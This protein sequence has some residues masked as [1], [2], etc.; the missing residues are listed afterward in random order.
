MLRGPRPAASTGEQDPP[1]ATAR[2]YPTRQ[3]PHSASFVP[4]TI[5]PDPLDLDPLD[6]SLSLRS[7]YP[8]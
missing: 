5:G 6:L 8:A 2:D 7:Q 1:I 4:N 3:T